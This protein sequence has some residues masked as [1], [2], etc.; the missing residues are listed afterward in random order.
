MA[1]FFLGNFDVEHR[2]ADA[3]YHPSRAM[4]RLCGELAPGWLA[5]AIDG[6]FVWCPTAHAASFFTRAAAHGLPRVIPVCDVRDAPAGV[7]VVPWGWSDEVLRLADTHRWRHDSPPMAA[8][9]AANSREFSFALESEWRGGLPGAATVVRE[10][11]LDEAC[12]CAR[13]ISARIVIKANWGM[14]GRERIVFDGLPSDAARA[15]VRKRLAV[16]RLVFVEPWVKRL[17]EV[18][19]QIDIPPDGPPR[20]VGM[21]VLLCDDVGQ[22]R[23]S[24]FTDPPHAGSDFH[25]RWRPALEMALRA[26]ERVQRLGYFGPLGVDAMRY[27]LADGTIGLRPLQDINARWTMGRLSLGWRRFLQES[28]CGLWWHGAEDD[29]YRQITDGAHVR[30][31]FDLTLPQDNAAPPPRRSQVMFLA[32]PAADG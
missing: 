19:V 27:R 30:R 9:R 2:L 12:R 29:V 21:T 3:G 8:V 5:V 25:S 20:P 23:G 31:V 26:A 7:E 16:H 13:R 18:G 24:W 15:W 14:S 22:Y 6:D 32:R 4:Q 11:Q 10:D 17:E 1:R 28:E